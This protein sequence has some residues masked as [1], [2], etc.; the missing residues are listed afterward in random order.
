[1]KTKKNQ[2]TKTYNSFKCTTHLLQQMLR[3]QKI[4][5]NKKKVIKMFKDFLKYLF[6]N[7]ISFITLLS[8]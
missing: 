3:V 4:R 6:Q 8:I 5:K 2:K 1:M 7:N